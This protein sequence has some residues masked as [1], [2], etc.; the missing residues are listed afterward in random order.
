MLNIVP[1]IMNENTDTS[2]VSDSILSEKEINRRQKKHINKLVTVNGFVELII[3][4]T[5]ESKIIIASNNLDANLIILAKSRGL[6]SID[7]L[8]G[9]LTLYHDT[10]LA[11]RLKHS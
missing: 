11:Y 2:Q 1:D 9:K 3:H 5:A 4:E 6:E 10:A 8:E 7:N